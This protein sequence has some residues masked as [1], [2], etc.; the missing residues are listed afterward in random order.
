MVKKDETFLI[1]TNSLITPYRR[2]YAFD[3]APSFWEKLKEHF[4]SGR[5]VIL[6]KVWDELQKGGSEDEL[7]RWLKENRDSFS[8]CTYKTESTVGVYAEV[9]QYVQTSD[10][11]NESAIA[12]WAIGTVADPWIIAAAKS[13][14]YTIVTEEAGHQ[15]LSS[16]QKAKQAKVPDVANALNI[17]AITL[18]DMMR[19]LKIVI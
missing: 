9:L 11:Y 15:N 18:F 12:S 17:S 2:Y 14:G 4:E 8:I 10:L 6:D 3:L 16:K 19:R 1:D 5:I 7:A 13:N